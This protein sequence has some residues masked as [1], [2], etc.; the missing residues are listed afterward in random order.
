[1]LPIIIAKVE[2]NANPT[3]NS[4]V[5]VGVLEN[6]TQSTNVSIK[7]LLSI[8]AS[9]APAFP[10]TMANTDKNNT[11]VRMIPIR[12][13]KNKSWA[14]NSNPYK[15]DIINR[16]FMG[17]AMMKVTML[18]KAITLI[19]EFWLVKNSA[20]KKLFRTNRTIVIIAKEQ[21]NRN[22]GETAYS[23]IYQI[24]NN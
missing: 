17:T 19:L 24:L 7:I 21:A 10:F 5:V 13:P 9:A 6:I 8:N 18:C 16:R 3:Q 1:M 4:W 11:N 15:H 23:S 2:Q 20:I 22:S 12:E 14:R